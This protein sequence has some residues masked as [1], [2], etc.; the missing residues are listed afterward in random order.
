MGYTKY[1]PQVKMG[2]FEDWKTMDRVTNTSTFYLKNDD[3]L[4]Y[5][6]KSREEA[7]EWIEMHKRSIEAK[8]VITEYEK[9]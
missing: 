9:V 3:A 7:L 6:V 8:K 4:Q 1:Y 2:L 5:F